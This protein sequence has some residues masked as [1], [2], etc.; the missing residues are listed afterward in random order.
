MYI[1]AEDGSKAVIKARYAKA[2]DLLDGL[3]ANRDQL[4]DL[5]RELEQML[6]DAGVEPSPEPDHVRYEYM[7]PLDD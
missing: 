2:Q 4:G 3:I 6:R 7:P 5:G 1:E